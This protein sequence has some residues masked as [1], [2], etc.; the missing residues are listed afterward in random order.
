M[1]RREGHVK[2]D[3]RRMALAL[4]GLMSLAS[5]GCVRSR[6]EVMLILSTNA[7]CGTVDRVKITIYRA[8]SS[9][10]TYDQTFARADCTP[11]LPEALPRSPLAADREFRLGIV[12]SKRSDDRVRIDVQGIGVNGVALNASVETDFVDDMVYG[13]PV[14]LSVQCVGVAC[15]AG[16]SC[17]LRPGTGI[18]ACGSIYRQPGTFGTFPMAVTILDPSDLDGRDQ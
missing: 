6:R 13:V 4:T 5:A 11:N 15:G 10:A 7:P 17:A 16:T 12:D 3:F 2:V 14:M 18:A 9:V 1:R 8:G